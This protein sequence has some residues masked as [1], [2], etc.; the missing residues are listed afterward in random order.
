MYGGLLAL[1]ASSV[2]ADPAA[3]PNDTYF[4]QQW[5][6]CNTGQAV[7]GHPDG[8]GL[9]GADIGALAAWELHRGTAAVVVA[10]V[11]AGVDPHPEFHARLTEGFVAVDAGGDPYSTLETGAHGT[12]IAG[13][14]G[15]TT[16]NG[17]GI[18]GVQSQVVLL[19]IRAL[20]G[21]VGTAD[22]AAQGILWAVDHDAEIVVVPLAFFDS[23]VEALGDAVAYAAANDVLVIAPTGNAGNNEVGFPAQF[24]GCLAVGATS[25][26]DAF[27]CECSNYGG[28]MDLVAPGVDIL[29][30]SAGGGYEYRSGASIATGF[31][32]GVAALVLSYAPQLRAAEVAQLLVD[33]ADDLGVQQCGVETFQ[34]SRLNADRALQMAPPPP[35]R[36]EWANEPP[37]VVEPGAVSSIEVIITDVA[38]HCV[39]ASLH[40][41][42]G[43]EGF[44]SIPMSAVGD[45]R[46]VGSLPAVPCEIAMEY[47]V[48]ALGHEGAEIVD[49]RDAPGRTYTAVAKRETTLFHDDFEEDL[50]WTGLPAGAAN[51]SGAWTRVEP[52]GTR[53]GSPSVQAQPEYDRTPD[54]GTV[55]FI[56]GQHFGGSVGSADVDGGPVSLVSPVIP[57]D[58]WGTEISYSRWFF[59]V[60]GEPDELVVEF[61]R[62]A[63][64]NW[65]VVEVVESTGTW[66][67]RSFRLSEYP[68]IVGSSLRVRF[69]TADL[70]GPS[71]TEAAIDDFE[72]RSIRCETRPGDYDGDG[73]IGLSDFEHMLHCWQGPAGNPSDG[74]CTLMDLNDDGTVDMLD[75]SRFQQIFGT[76]AT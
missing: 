68:E 31:V 73:L 36:L 70:N 55:C 12:H 66:V 29:S 57:L 50:G 10:V 24:S 65:T 62:D 61:S 45:A 47:Y 23:D 51:S 49:P 41:R 27:A 11:D 53:T 20:E 44:V 56:T 72:V 25:N 18:A 16:N 60:S 43:S 63:G 6:L 34:T 52:V 46:Y 40:Y 58:G 22:S 7:D 71:L 9:V 2:T 3:V 26:R 37:A 19:P 54:T 1:F 14:I 74:W 64:V 17:M 4:S 69:T 30:T 13:I 35:L 75:F 5:G 76:P 28:K 48:T 21:N 33:S 67:D 42:T 39:S 8:E 38:Q 15:A 59:S 32:A